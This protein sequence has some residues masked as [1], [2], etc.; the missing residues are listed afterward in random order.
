MN[1]IQHLQKLILGLAILTPVGCQSP[2]PATDVDPTVEQTSPESRDAGVSSDASSADEGSPQGDSGEA[3]SAPE[4]ARELVSHATARGAA[5][6]M[7]V[8]LAREQRRQ[9]AL[10]RQRDRLA[11]MPKTCMTLDEVYA[12]ERRLYDSEAALWTS[13]RAARREAKKSKNRPGPGRGLLGPGEKPKRPRKAK[14]CPEA[15]LT[16]ISRSRCQ[17]NVTNLQLESTNES[18]SGDM[19]CCYVDPSYGR[20][21]RACGRLF[22]VEDRATRART[23]SD[24]TWMG[25][26]VTRPVGVSEELAMQAAQAWLDDAL[27]EHAS[28]AAFSRATLE[29]MAM[30]APSELLAE[31]QR[32]SLDEIRHARLC[33][34]LVGAL[35]GREVSAGAIEVEGPRDDLDAIIEDVFWGGC[36]GESV[37]ALCAQ[38][39]LTGCTWEP[40]R[41]ALEQISGDEA[42]HA[43]LAWSTLSFFG[44]R[45]PERLR[46]L[47]E[48]AQRPR[49]EHTGVREDEDAWRALGRLTPAQ[50]ARAAEDAWAHL[51]AP[52]IDELLAG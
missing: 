45:H 41:Q 43:A 32:A 51:I 16:N 50:E 38:R 37:A 40:A 7:R 26:D 33:F 13:Q 14:V 29:L 9:E 2:P 15:V 36:V 47:L 35:L 21:R 5:D 18:E 42:R 8:A 4:R 52:M 20:P 3:L 48:G 11:S 27:E 44:P 19:V 30:G 46:R 17:T 25:E 34:S 12:A 1:D 6:A 31:Y 39:S 49:A 28:I 22:Y 24:R 23:E 10:Q